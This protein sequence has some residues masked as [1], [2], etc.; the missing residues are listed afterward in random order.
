MG[1]YAITA[2][3]AVRHRPAT[4]AAPPVSPAP[5]PAA[6]GAQAPEVTGPLSAGSPAPAAASG[7]PHLLTELDDGVRPAAGIPT[8][9]APEKRPAP[10]PEAQAVP[11]G[12]AA[13]PLY[14]VQVG[15]FLTRLEAVQA[16][17]RLLAQGYPTYVTAAR[18]SRVLVGACGRGLAAARLVAEL[19]TKRHANVQLVGP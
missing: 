12:P 11:V 4:T 16:A 2:V 9:P 18:P 10:A 13:V 15:P 3:T 7:D 14:R 19:Q 5:A 8:R 6:P 1:N 17:G